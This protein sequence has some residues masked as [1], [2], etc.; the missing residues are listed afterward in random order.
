MSLQDILP[1]YRITFLFSKSS[2]F[3]IFFLF[4]FCVLYSSTPFLVSISAPTETEYIFPSASLMRSSAHTSSVLSKPPFLEITVKDAT[5]SSLLASA[6]VE[7]F[8]ASDN[9]VASGL[10]DMNGFLNITDLELGQYR[11]EVSYS[12]IYSLEKKLVIFDV[13]GEFKQL[14]IFLIPYSAL[15]AAVEVLVQDLEQIPLEATLVTLFDE[16]L[17]IISSDWTNSSGFTIFTPLSVGTYTIIA[18]KT[19]FQNQSHSFQVEWF[20]QSI[21][22]PLCLSPANTASAFIEM[23]IRDIFSK[24]T[25]PF[26]FIEVQ[27]QFGHIVANQQTDDLGFVNITDLDM[28][29]YSVFFHLDSYNDLEKLVKLHYPLDSECLYVSLTSS[30]LN[31]GAITVKVLTEDATPIINA[32]VD[33]YASDDT[34]LRTG[35]TN[36]FGTYSFSALETGMYRVSVSAP[37]YFDQ[38]QEVIIRWINDS[39]ALDF[40]LTNREGVIP[41]QI[42]LA[43]PYN[44]PVGGALVKLYDSNNIFVQAG[45]SDDTGMVTLSD[46]P[47]DI[48]NLEISKSGFQKKWFFNVNP[49]KEF[50]EGISHKFIP[51][52]GTGIINI[53]SLANSFITVSNANEELLF[54]GFSSSGSFSIPN[55][56][57]GDYIIDIY[58]E[59]G[60]QSHSS[61][62]NWL[63]DVN[64]IYA[65]QV[66]EQIDTSGYMEFT[67]YEFN[68]GPI[69]SCY[70]TAK[71]QYDVYYSG[72][73]DENGFVNITGLHIGMYE[74]TAQHSGFVDTIV[75]HSIDY[76]GDSSAASL[77]LYRATYD[78]EVYITEA[79][80]GDPYQGWIRYRW[81]SEPWSSVYMSDNTGFRRFNNLPV[82]VYEFCVITGGY[83]WQYQNF[84]TYIA[85]D[86]HV[87]HFPLVVPG[88]N[89]I[90]EHFALIVGGG[91]ED[92]FTHDARGMYLTLTNY[93]GFTPENTYLLTCEAMDWV[94]NVPVPYD[95]I[96]SL[97]TLTWAINDIASKADGEDEV[98]IWWTGHGG[99]SLHQTTAAILDGSFTLNGDTIT[100]TAF[101]TLI[102]GITCD[103]MYIFLGPCHSGYWIGK[104]DGES[105]RAI[106]TSCKWDEIAHAFYEHSYWPRATKRA[107]DPF[108]DADTADDDNNAK[109]SLY[110]LYDYAKHWVQVTKNQDQHP[111]RW[112]GFIGGDSNLYIGDES[113]T[114]GFGA[115]TRLNFISKRSLIQYS[116][117]TES[118][119]SLDTQTGIVTI[120]SIGLLDEELDNDD[121]F[122]NFYNSSMFPV[123]SPISDV[124]IILRF[125]NGTIFSSGY[126]N[127]DGIYNYFDLP[128]GLCAWEAIYNALTIGSGQIMTDGVE[129]AIF[130]RV[131][132]YDRQGDAAD[133]QV[134][135]SDVSEATNLAGMMVSLYHIDGSFISNVT[136]DFDGI[137]AFYDLSDGVYG[138]EVYYQMKLYA[139]GNIVIDSATFSLS[140]DLT[141]P[142]VTIMSPA[143]G[144]I[145]YTSDIPIK[146]CYTVVEVYNYSL[147]VFLN[148]IDIG[149]KL[150]GSDLVEISTSGIY[151]LRI[152]VVDFAGNL[153]SA[154][155]SFTLLVPTSTSTTRTSSS[156]PLTTKNVLWPIGS[157]QIFCCIFL[158]I[159]RRKRR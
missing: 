140:S 54:S 141:A 146:L 59:E 97:S 127:V 155:V 80:T 107:L 92:R 133:L 55:L 113:Y 106:Y 122:I 58:S 115:V 104:L 11:V 132:N 100:G 119:Q 154:E 47:L 158:V 33:L 22:I 67:V 68:V 96:S 43:D 128:D 17:G 105:N 5:N 16:D 53:Y 88:G 91:T 24:A 111:Q 112:V 60:I 62:I 102:D 79:L 48:Y 51:A 117:E 142:G 84:T 73:T 6:F 40:S 116:I 94:A 12:R 110:E 120:V 144:S 35:S 156:T 85:G 90:E 23:Y 36:D 108:Y 130:T 118:T 21:R 37:L 70:V 76:A 61:S 29:L 126:S 103:R 82:G 64:S 83:E 143:D 75:Y 77:Y 45:W 124:Q 25:L 159:I 123:Y 44:R 150:N 74:V 148:N 157:I 93:Y 57:I 66:T 41:L 31:Q 114:A 89:G 109:I 10:T 95:A 34:F 71:S 101:D 65:D 4:G 14:T 7:V 121:C 145:Y 30:S 27:D 87:L 134:Q 135:I 9:S 69:P 63:G 78:V 147:T 137:A 1:R 56:A 149:F 2:V 151:T 125:L 39:R 13:E 20:G 32:V 3:L 46:L 139:E 81:N 131:D 129:L 18:S 72:I 99:F 86:F 8:N 38:T 153:G 138:F 15:K 49:F 50:N 28:G 26:V 152:E 136:S 98:L 52:A 19:G 42:S